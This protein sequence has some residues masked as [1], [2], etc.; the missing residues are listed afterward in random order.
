[1]K[2]LKSL[3][4]FDFKRQGD[5]RHEFKAVTETVES[6]REFLGKRMDSVEL[7]VDSLELS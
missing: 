2:F 7:K 3:K 6:S 1:M 4:L 5:L